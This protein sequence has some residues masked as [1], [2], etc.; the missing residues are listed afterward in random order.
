MFYLA[1]L[2]LQSYLQSL[3]ILLANQL[4][5]PPFKAISNSQLPHP[6]SGL[7]IPSS[8]L[9]NASGTCFTFWVIASDSLPNVLPLHNASFLPGFCETFLTTRQPLSKL[10]PRVSGFRDGGL[11]LQIAGTASASSCCVTTRGLGIMQ[12]TLVSRPFPCE[13]EIKG[14]RISDK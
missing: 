13:L 4:S 12:H 7:R 11:P 8:N 14:E 5:R 10:L 6:S 3:G 1:T 2:Q 9:T